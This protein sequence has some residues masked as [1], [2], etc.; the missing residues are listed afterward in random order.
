M[1]D[2]KWLIKKWG[3]LTLVVLLVTIAGLLYWDTLHTK[4]RKIAEG[5]EK[6]IKE[7]INSSEGWNVGD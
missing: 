7:L 4:N 1:E 6:S 3:L 2:V 5:F